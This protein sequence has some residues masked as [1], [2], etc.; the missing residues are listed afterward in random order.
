MLRAPAF[1]LVGNTMPER[2]GRRS[3]LG[4]PLGPWGAGL[5]LLA[6]RLPLAASPELLPPEARCA[7]YYYN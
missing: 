4:Y 6:L 3:R 7:G 2:L 1:E 5:A